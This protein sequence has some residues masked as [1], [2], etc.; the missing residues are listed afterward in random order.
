[1]LLVGL[2]GGVGAGKSTVADLLSD[3]GAVIIDAD[4]IARKVVEPGTE[5]FTLVHQAFGDE[6]LTHD[7]ALDRRALAALVFRDVEARRR[8]E[9]IVHPLV[10]RHVDLMTALADDDAIVVHDV[11]LLVETGRQGDYD[12][13][14]V[15]EAP[16]DQRIA[17]LRSSRGWDRETSQARMKAQASDE[18]RR[19]AADEIVTND[20]DR[21]L[22]AARVDA[23]WER[24]SERALTVP[25]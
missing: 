6:I 3:H 9:Q 21:D 4:V 20:G 15:V 19:T 10:R 22:L 8:L 7:G 2:T 17:R 14:V 11:P 12:V 1:V 23:L 16:H 13:V 18:A 5:G 24:L 25:S